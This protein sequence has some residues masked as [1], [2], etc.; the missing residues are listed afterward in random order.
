MTKKIGKK[1]G[2]CLILGGSLCF[3]GGLVLLIPPLT[4]AGAAALF[5]AIGIV[6]VGTKSIRDSNLRKKSRRLSKR[7]SQ[8]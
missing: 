7:Q 1:T 3:V 8:T 5:S 6:G 2:F 4:P